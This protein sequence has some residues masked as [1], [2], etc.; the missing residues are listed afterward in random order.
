MNSSDTVRVWWVPILTRGKY[1][2]EPL[3]ENFPGET[4][5]GAAIMVAKVRAALNVRFPAGNAPRVFFTDRGNRF[6]RDKQN[7]ACVQTGA[8][9]SEVAGVFQR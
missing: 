9:R 7:H 5:E 4:E 8:A 6:F 2:V 3:P 1:H